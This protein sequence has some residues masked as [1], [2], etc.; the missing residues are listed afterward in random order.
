MSAGYGQM[1]IKPM[2]PRQA[3]HT[4]MIGESIRANSQ[5]DIAAKALQCVDEFH[6][7]NTEQLDNVVS[8][9]RRQLP[10]DYEDE[11]LN[12]GFRDGGK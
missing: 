8:D 4:T 7:T 10:D 12:Y 1:S 5:R 3:A 6:N 2:T 9:Y 11:L